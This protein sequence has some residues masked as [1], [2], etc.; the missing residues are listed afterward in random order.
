MLHHF[1]IPRST[2]LLLAGT[3]GVLAHS[4][5]PTACA[6]G[7]KDEGDDASALLSLRSSVSRL[8]QKEPCTVSSHVTCPGSG[9]ACHG[10]QCCPRHAL[11]N[12]LTFPCPSADEGFAGCENN[13]KVSN[14]RSAGDPTTPATPSPEQQWPPATTCKTKPDC[15]GDARPP[16]V[17]NETRWC[18]QNE[19][20]HY[21]EATFFCHRCGTETNVGRNLIE[22]IS[23]QCTCRAINFADN[24]PTECEHPDN[25]PCEQEDAQCAVYDRPGL[26]VCKAAGVP[27]A[28]CE[29]AETEQN[30]FAL[31]S[32]SNCPAEMKTPDGGGGISS[33]SPATSCFGIKGL[34][35]PTWCG[36]S[37]SLHN[38]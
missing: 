8:S 36:C 21:P 15:M 9:N 13:T 37:M 30:G 5:Q 2:V 28:V 10:N 29:G 7:G 32:C 23:E 24:P 11:S 35:G 1:T 25:T 17:T 31:A 34:H 20:I 14:C 26:E 22:C 33:V 12:D 27:D 3:F 4:E 18:I 16:P 19:S 38:W 6:D